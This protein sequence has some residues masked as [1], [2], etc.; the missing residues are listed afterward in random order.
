[1]KEAQHSNHFIL[2]PAV[3]DLL[4]N[5]RKWGMFSDGIEQDFVELQAGTTARLVWRINSGIGWGDNKGH[6]RTGVEKTWLT[7]TFFKL[8]ASVLS[9]HKAKCRS[10]ERLRQ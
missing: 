6:L 9:V 3:T 10:L 4:A 7:L 8:I 1:M 2:P 5:V